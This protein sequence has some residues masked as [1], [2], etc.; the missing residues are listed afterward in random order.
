MNNRQRM[1]VSNELARDYFLNLG[2]DWIAFKAHALRNDVAWCRDSDGFKTKDFKKYYTDHFNLFD[3][4]MLGG[5]IV[6]F[7]IKTNAWAK[8]IPVKEFCVKYHTSAYIINV[9]N[10]LVQCKGKYKVFARQ[11]HE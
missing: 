5:T 4:Y 1:R 6:W 9:T 3:G 11:Y 10:K 7:Q 8:A 2:Y